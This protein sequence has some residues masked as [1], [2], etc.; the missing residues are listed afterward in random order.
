LALD[1]DL[2]VAL[3][4]RSVARARPHAWPAL[5]AEIEAIYEDRLP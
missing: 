5:T 3:S 1:G 2:Q 4:E